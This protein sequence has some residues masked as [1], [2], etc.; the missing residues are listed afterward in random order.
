MPRMFFR[1]VGD[2]DPYGVRTFAF[3]KHEAALVGTGLP[4]GP[5]FDI[6]F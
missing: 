4:D 1:V 6:A 5:F 3:A 2:V